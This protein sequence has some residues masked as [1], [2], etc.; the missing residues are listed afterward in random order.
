MFVLSLQ[1]ILLMI[2]RGR[3]GE[4]L[5]HV[6]VPGDVF[7]LHCFKKLD[8]PWVRPTAPIR[9]PGNIFKE[10]FQNMRN[11]IGVELF[12][13]WRDLRTPIKHKIVEGSLKNTSEETWTDLKTFTKHDKYGGKFEKHLCGLHSSHHGNFGARSLTEET[14]IVLFFQ[15]F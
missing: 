9:E 1:V 11:D 3:L 10:H 7:C 4:N 13:T 5:G 15:F 6:E 14:G 12:G 8:V 2:N